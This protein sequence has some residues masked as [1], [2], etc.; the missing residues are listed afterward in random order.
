MRK[1]QGWKKLNSKIKYRNPWIKIREDSVIRL[2]GK[3]SIYAFL[4]KHAGSFIIA[5]DKDDSIYF[6]KEFRYPLQKIV[7]QLP[8]GVVGAKNILENTKKELREETGII[9]SSWKRLGGFY[10]APGHE[11]TYINVFLA[12]D[13]DTTNLKVDFQEDDELILDVVKIKLSKVKK[14]IIKGE[15]ECGLTLAALNIFFLEK[16]K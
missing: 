15:I 3:K 2:D 7:L 5:L 9:A 13:L 14:M 8:A 4:E 1:Y 10:I 11:T 12:T 6:V 16:N